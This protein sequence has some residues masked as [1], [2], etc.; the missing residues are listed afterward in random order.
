MENGEISSCV[1]AKLRAFKLRCRFSLK[2]DYNR[3]VLIQLCFTE[4]EVNGQRLQ[5]RMDSGM[6][7]S[8]ISKANWVSLGQPVLSEP[9][10]LL[11]TEND[12]TV[13]SRDVLER[14]QDPGYARIR[15]RR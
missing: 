13:V 4:V 12:T 3:I 2:M 11:I 8:M 5:L 7:I 15:K 6:S 10:Q 9:D 14:F 1:N